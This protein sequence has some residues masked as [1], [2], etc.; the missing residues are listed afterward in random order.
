MAVLK[1]KT[2]KRLQKVLLKHGSELVAGLAAGIV[3]KVLD[4]AGSGLESALDDR[5]GGKKGKRRRRKRSD[6]PRQLRALGGRM[7][8]LLPADTIV[9]AIRSLASSPRKLSSQRDRRP[10]SSKHSDGKKHGAN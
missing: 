7:A 3:T 2:R 10:K 1:K 5:G 6:L 4:L 9:S 8:E